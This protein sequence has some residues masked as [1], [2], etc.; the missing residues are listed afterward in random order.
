MFRGYSSHHWSTQRH[1]WEIM[2]KR[3]YP[4]PAE[5][6]IEPSI[7]ELLADQTM[8][9]LLA[10]D[11]LDVSDVKAVIREWRMLNIDMPGTPVAA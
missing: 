8:H 4:F 10:R 11:G 2:M 6:G 7:T 5:G 1:T 3:A 9:L